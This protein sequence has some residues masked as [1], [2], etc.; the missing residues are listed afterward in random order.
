VDVNS[1]LNLDIEELTLVGFSPLAHKRLGA[2]V[3]E[4]LARLFG[5]NGVP[6]WLEQRSA[7]PI[8]DGGAFQVRAGAPEGVLGRQI[9]GAVYRAMNGGLK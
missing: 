8:L 2:V 1:R 7:L 4:E 5:E 6:G 3:E 9:A